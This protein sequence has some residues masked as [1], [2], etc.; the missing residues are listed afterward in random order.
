VTWNGLTTLVAMGATMVLGYLFQ[1]VMA[2]RLTTLEYGELS[3][4]LATLNVMTIPVFG[5][6]MA[7][8]RDVAAAPHTGRHQLIGI[9][10]LYVLRVACI[11]GAMAARS[12][13]VC[14]TSLPRP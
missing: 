9:V 12:C 2:R 13:L 14:T 6:C 3:A 10:R 4:I 1:V 7:V 8:T 5:L 11:T